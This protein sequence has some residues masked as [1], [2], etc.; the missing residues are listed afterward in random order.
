MPLKKGGGSKNQID[1]GDEMET[2][3]TKIEGTIIDFNPGKKIGKIAGI[4]GEY[5]F[6]HRHDV[7]RGIPRE[8]AGVTFQISTRPVKEDYLPYAV[9][10]NVIENVETGAAALGQPIQH[11]QP[12]Q[13]VET[14]GQKAADAKVGE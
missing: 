1:S 12:S 9:V 4:N 3:A 8:G 13:T 5:Y 2:K 7:M 11:I 14:D 6:F 10:I